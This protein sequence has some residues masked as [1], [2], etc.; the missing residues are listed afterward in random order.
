MNA[1]ILKTPSRIV[2]ICTGCGVNESG[3]PHWNPKHWAEQESEK[4]YKVFCPSCLKRIKGVKNEKKTR[5]A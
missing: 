4:G 3:D 2:L 1:N 5:Q